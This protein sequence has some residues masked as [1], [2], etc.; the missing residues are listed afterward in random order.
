M[1]SARRLV[2][3]GQVPRRLPLGCPGTA[4]HCGFRDGG[5]LSSA[6]TGDPP[7]DISAT[8]WSALRITVKPIPG[9]HLL[10]SSHSP[11][12]FVVAATRLKGRRTP[13]GH[14]GALTAEADGHTEEEWIQIFVVW[15]L[16]GFGYL[17]ICPPIILNVL[18]LRWFKRSTLETYF[19]FMAVFLFFPALLL[20]APFVNFRQL[21]KDPSKLP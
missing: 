1:P 11:T 17:F 7:H 14:I 16:V 13:T 15:A 21:P 10:G 5:A 6:A 4:R 18:R 9:P 19:Q 3:Q 2:N 20:W 8:G 12:L